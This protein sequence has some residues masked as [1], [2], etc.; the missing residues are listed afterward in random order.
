[1]LDEFYKSIFRKKVFS[2]VG[3]LQVELDA[4]IERY[5]HERTHQGKRCQGRTPMATF[6][7]GLGLARK[8]DLM[9][10]DKLTA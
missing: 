8:A 4:W 1:V 6:I 9:S 3:D 10:E 7:D 5:N 2:T